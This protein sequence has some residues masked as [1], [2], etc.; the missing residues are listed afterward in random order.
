MIKAICFFCIVCCFI[1]CK[2][3]DV[4][5]GVLPKEKMEAVLWDYISADL[6]VK[7]ILS[8]DSA[9]NMKDAAYRMQEKVFALHHI[10]RKT[11][12]KSYDWYESHDAV[13]MPMLDSIAAKQARNVEKERVAEQKK[14][15]TP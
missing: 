7:N 3:N 6:Y 4:P 12:T 8:K 2:N 15:N 1:S 13:F 11:F 14:N 9:N 5:K 10:D